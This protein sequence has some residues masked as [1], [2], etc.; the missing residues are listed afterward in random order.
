M[1]SLEIVRAFI[2]RLNEINPI[3]NAIVQENF[4]EALYQAK[5]IDERIHQVKKPV[6]TLMFFGPYWVEGKLA[7]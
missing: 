1:T 3:L 2:V 6:N 4:Q 5:M 7:S